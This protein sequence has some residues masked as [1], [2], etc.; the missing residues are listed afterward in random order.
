MIG[1]STFSD[2][3]SSEIFEET[4]FHEII[5]NKKKY[6]M[7]YLNTLKKSYEEFK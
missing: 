2:L 1:Y 7:H 5:N 6:Y 4:G 3:L